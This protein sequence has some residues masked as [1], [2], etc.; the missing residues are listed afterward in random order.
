MTARLLAALLGALAL[1]ISS[2]SLAQNQGGNQGGN[3]QGGS[4]AAPEFDAQTAALGIALAGTAIVAIRG[5]L[6]RPRQ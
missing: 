3:S 6:R 5:R 4:V 1:C 2:A